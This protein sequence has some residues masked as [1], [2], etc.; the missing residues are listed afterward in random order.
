MSFVSNQMRRHSYIEEGLQSFDF[1]AAQSP[2]DSFLEFLPQCG[3]LLT[4]SKAIDRYLQL[5]S[6]NQIAVLYFFIKGMYG[7]GGDRFFNRLFSF[8]P[9]DVQTA[10]SCKNEDGY[11]WTHLAAFFNRDVIMEHLLDVDF[12]IRSVTNRCGETPLQIAL[13]EESFSL[14]SELMEKLRKK[15]NLFTE[16]VFQAKIW[17]GRFS[18][19]GPLFEGTS[20]VHKLPLYESIERT[21]ALAGE[22]VADG[23][24]DDRVF[25]A[26]ND[27]VY[28][29]IKQT[30]EQR[31]DNV[32]KTSWVMLSTGY[33]AHAT[34]HLFSYKEK[35]CVKVDTGNGKYRGFKV[36]RIGKSDLISI[37]V[38]MKILVLLK[39][40]S[41][42]RNLSRDYWRYVKKDLNLTRVKFFEA[43]QVV[44]NCAL[45]SNL[46]AVRALFMLIHQKET[47]GSSDEEACRNYHFWKKIDDQEAFEYLLINLR[48]MPDT[49]YKKQRIVDEILC[50]AIKKAFAEDDRF[51]AFLLAEQHKYIDFFTNDLKNF[52]HLELG[53][54]LVRMAFQH[55]W[56]HVIIELIRLNADFHLPDGEGKTVFDD[57]DELKLTP[58]QIE[59]LLHWYQ[60]EASRQERQRFEVLAR[61]L[62]WMR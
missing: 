6:E 5:D 49:L 4:S 54:S 17:G 50:Y 2:A 29:A 21:L 34:I 27:V 24:L 41:V 43:A 14:N 35:L 28:R 48:N 39:K 42:S 40:K 7:E 45:E 15:D 37:K 60:K 19:S 46:V 18:L 57:A 8:S 22:Y 16:Q 30:P 10:I 58:Q 44:G 59:E 36:Y 12:N 62:R 26:V 33:K 1:C 38:M 55:R 13:I 25:A 51:F 56:T 47:S 32:S 61:G 31:C 23:S 52:R 3:A 9:S 20:V 11:T 53:K